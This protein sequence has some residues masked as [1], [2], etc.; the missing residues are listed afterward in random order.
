MYFLVV[1]E[2]RLVCVTV[3]QEST[4][5]SRLGL[6]P[7]EPVSTQACDSGAAQRSCCVVFFA[8]VPPLGLTLKRLFRAV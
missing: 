3:Y 5:V 2:T 7:H 8:K 1:M 4:N 6:F